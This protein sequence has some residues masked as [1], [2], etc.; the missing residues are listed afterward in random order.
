MH[1]RMNEFCWFTSQKSEVSAT[2][3]ALLESWIMF[4]KQKEFHGQTIYV[5]IGD[6]NI[7]VNLGKKFL[8]YLCDNVKPTC[9][10]HGVHL[11]YCAPGISLGFF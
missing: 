10:F 4:F 5:G 6:D 3:E 9:T 7:P 11:P 1:A 2:I 8:F